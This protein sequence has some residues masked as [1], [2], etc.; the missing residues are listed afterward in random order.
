SKENDITL[1]ANEIF[2]K[3]ASNI[4]N[5]TS[6]RSM[7]FSIMGLYH[8]LKKRPNNEKLLSLM[9]QLRLRLCEF[10]DANK[11]GEWQ[12]FEGGLTYCNAVLP[13]ALLYSLELMP[14]DRVQTIAMETTA[15]LKKL[16]I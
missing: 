2:G 5:L 7:A 12:W 3:A 16:T 9:H 15:F 4:I 1:L 6:P 13:L 10:Y 11:D 8:Y 14:D